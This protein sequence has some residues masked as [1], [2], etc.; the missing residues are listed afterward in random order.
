[1]KIKQNLQVS[2]G[3]FW[4][5]LTSGGYIKPTEICENQEDAAN[6][7]EAIAVIEDFQSSCEQ[8]IDGFLQ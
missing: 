4:Y 3:D 2:T 7:I 8:Q 6:V 5:D 1:M